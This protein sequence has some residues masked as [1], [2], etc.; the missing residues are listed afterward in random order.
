MGIEGKKRQTTFV[1]AGVRFQQGGR[2]L[3]SMES[4]QSPGMEKEH[5]WTMLSRLS[6]GSSVTGDDK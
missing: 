2:T 6:P 3:G 5:C 4:R 1:P